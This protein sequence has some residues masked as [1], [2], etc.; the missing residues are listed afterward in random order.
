MDDA[1]ASVH[2]EANSQNSR[3]EV[4]PDRTTEESVVREFFETLRQVANGSQSMAAIDIGEG[5]FHGNVI[6]RVHGTLS[7]PR[8]E[9]VIGVGGVPTPNHIHAGA[10]VH[11]IK[12]RKVGDNA[13]AA[14]RLGPGEEKDQT[15]LGRDGVAGFTGGIEHAEP[16]EGRS[17]DQGEVSRV[18]VTSSASV[19]GKRLGNAAEILWVQRGEERAQVGPAEMSL[20]V[21]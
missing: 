4:R 13:P 16:V 18:E 15:H 17:A 19:P 3:W 20:L 5:V 8:V 11:P 1:A 14:R 9:M 10:G 2:R 6:D 7:F 12:G 21:S